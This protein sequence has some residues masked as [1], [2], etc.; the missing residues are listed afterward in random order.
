MPLQTTQKLTPNSRDSRTRIN[1][2]RDWV[3]NDIVYYAIHDQCEWVVPKDR[4][5]TALHQLTGVRWM[6]WI[7]RSFIGIN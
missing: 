1:L 4:S 6:D 3:S 5:F 7:H 2:E